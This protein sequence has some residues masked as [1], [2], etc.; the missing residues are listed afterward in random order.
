LFSES[1]DFLL[2]KPLQKAGT[3][4]IVPAESYLKITPETQIGNFQY[5]SATSHN[6]L[7][8]FLQFWKWR[9]LHLTTTKPGMTAVQK[10]KSFALGTVL[11]ANQS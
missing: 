8:T 4:I 3:S 9:M 11:L 6:A 1:K 2:Y 7:H 5:G 10:L